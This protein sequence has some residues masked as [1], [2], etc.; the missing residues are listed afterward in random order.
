MSI[1]VSYAI[2]VEVIWW[3]ILLTISKNKNKQHIHGGKTSK[4][5][6]E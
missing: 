1:V 3:D 4:F 2:F 6:L 5:K